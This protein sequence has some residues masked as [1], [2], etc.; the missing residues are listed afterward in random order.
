MRRSIVGLAIFSLLAAVPA[1]AV[2][3]DDVLRMLDADVSEDVILKVVD[4]ERSRFVLSTDEIL[5][6]RYVGASDWFIDE[7]VERSVAPTRNRSYSVY[8]YN[9]PTY[10]SI[11]LVYDP[12]D[13]YFVTW[14][15]YYAYVSP[16]RFSW[17]WWYYGGPIHTHW[18]HPHGWRTVY[19]DRHWGPRSVWSRGYRRDPVRQVPRYTASEKELRRAVYDRTKGNPTKVVRTQG[20]TS[21]S[22][23]GRPSASGVERPVRRYDNRPSRVPSSPRREAV[24]GRSDRPR[25]SDSPNRPSVSPSRPQRGG[26][27]APPRVERPSR[28]APSKPSRPSR[29]GR[30]SRSSS[31]DRPSRGARR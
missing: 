30:S 21:R 2:S 16:F 25:R 12:F 11:G 27:S 22:V 17:T 9:H 14:P 7:M 4:A 29:S 26:S 10:V 8:D 15:Y 3:F 18:C 1:A 31:S 20:R 5:D 6:L 23:Y 24:W 19:Y 28:S 13:Y